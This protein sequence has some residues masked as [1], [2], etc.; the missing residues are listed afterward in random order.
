MIGLA[1]LMGGCIAV[2]APEEPAVSHSEPSPPTGLLLGRVSAGGASLD[3]VTYVPR[4]YAPDREW[5]C[6]VFLHG[7]GE[8]GRDGLKQVAQGLGQAILWDQERWPFIVIMPQKPEAGAMWEDYS[9]AVMA[10]L[11]EA[12]REFRIDPDRIALTGLSQ[13]GHGTWTLAAAYS[14]VWSAIVPICGFPGRS[15]GPG[16]DARAEADKLAPKIAHLPVWAFHG[17]A[18]R[19][20]PAEQTRVMIR[21][22]EAVGGTPRATYYPGVDHNSWDKAYREERAEGGV[23]AWLLRQRR[24]AR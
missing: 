22:L 21:A 17:E 3:V 5:P 14:D 4:G 16:S 7:R 6:I 2:R 18:D 9:Q 19:V 10:A 11:A 1:T 15:F 8:S 23:A 20:V 24:P 13:G 12:R